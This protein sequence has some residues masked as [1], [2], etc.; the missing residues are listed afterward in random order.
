MGAAGPPSLQH[1][2][3]LGHTPKIFDLLE[4]YFPGA[5]VTK[6]W[7]QWLDAHGRSSP[8]PHPSARQKRGIFLP[9]SPNPCLCSHRQVSEDGTVL[10]RAAALSCFP[11]KKKQ[12][13]T[14]TKGK[15]F[16]AS[17]TGSRAAQAARTEH[18][19]QRSDAAGPCLS[20]VTCAIGGKK[21]I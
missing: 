13:R 4:K 20:T 7:G 11:I 2:L 9:V 12:S 18:H 15:G 10:P 3:G 21:D 1:Q 14:Y 19:P 6:M 5:D 17:R 16:S 8:A